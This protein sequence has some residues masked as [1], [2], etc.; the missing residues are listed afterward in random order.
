MIAQIIGSMFLPHPNLY[1][2]QS[3]SSL[4]LTMSYVYFKIFKKDINL[5][6]LYLQSA[7][8]WALT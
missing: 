7:S 8:K 5:K 1:T 3:Q 6:N 2:N 4:L